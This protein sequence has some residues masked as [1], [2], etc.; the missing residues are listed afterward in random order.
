M[1][2]RTAEYNRGYEDAMVGCPPDYGQVSIARLYD[3]ID[4]YRAGRRD[5]VREGQ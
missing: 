4:G 5:R 1:A 2:K 3:Y